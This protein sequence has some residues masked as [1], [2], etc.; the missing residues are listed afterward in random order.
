MLAAEVAGFVPRG[1]YRRPRRFRVS[2]EH[3]LFPAGCVLIVV[4][5]KS[6]GATNMS[7]AGTSVALTSATKAVPAR[8]ASLEK[9]ASFSASAGSAP[10]GI[11][12]SSKAIDERPTADDN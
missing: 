4:C 9:S 6:H 8:T 7:A 2:F 10:N 12:P 5:L 3:T 11:S 1:E